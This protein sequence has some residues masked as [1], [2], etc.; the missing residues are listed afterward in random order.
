MATVTKPILKDET[1]S[2]KMDALI[3]CFGSHSLTIH[4][5]ESASG[6]FSGQEVRI[7]E[8]T[9]GVLAATVYVGTATDTVVSLPNNFNYLI[10]PICT[11]TNHYCEDKPSGILSANT[12]VNLV[13]H[14]LGDV[15][16]FTGLKAAVEAG[17]ASKV[18]IGTQVSFTHERYGNLVFDVV[19]YQDSDDS[20]MLLMHDCISDQ[21][22]F[23]AP[24]AAYG[25]KTTALAPG[26]Y[27]FK[28]SNTY[29]YFTTTVELPVGG[30]MVLKTNQFISYPNGISTVV[31]ESGSVSTTEI[32]D[33]TDLGTMGS[34]LNPMDRVN[35][36]S[37]IYT[38][39]ALDQ[40]LNATGDIANWWEPKTRFDRAPAYASTLPGFM[41]GVPQTVR[42]VIDNTTIRCYAYGYVSPDSSM[43]IGQ[44]TAQR[45]FFLASQRELYASGY[46]DDGTT[47]L[48]AF[49]G[50]GDS[51]KIKKY[52]SSARDWWLRS[53]YTNLFIEAFVTTSGSVNNSTANISVGVVP[54]C[55][56]SKSTI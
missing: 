52:N 11:L 6:S 56:I 3:A 37:N 26:D 46:V 45:K 34:Q 10:E 24:E 19:D 18:P 55:K 16:T 44:Y 41:K 33:A 2:A 35:Y 54:A 14:A 30:M 25:A 22:Q 31:L 15:N 23:D 1:Y 5:T 49:R 48:D 17:L 42:D 29:Y 12:T 47:Q 9:T 4:A 38:E 50:T 51:A 32:A 7:K 20:L 21:L 28:N 13:Y 40:W 8:A 36:G 53:P 39:S 27:K 43:N